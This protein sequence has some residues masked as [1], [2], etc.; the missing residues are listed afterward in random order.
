VNTFCLVEAIERLY[1][2]IVVAVTDRM[3]IGGNPSFGYDIRD[4]KLVVNDAEAETVH[5]IFRRYVAL[6]SVRLLVEESAQAG[7]TSKQGLNTSGRQ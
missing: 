3:R 4:R 6:R 2:R 7:I 5:Y 1:E